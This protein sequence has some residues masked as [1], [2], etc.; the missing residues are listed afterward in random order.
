VIRV[1]GRPSMRTIAS[2][3]A[4]ALLL[5]AAAATVAQTVDLTG[6]QRR[7]ALE[8]LQAMA[9]GDAQA[10]AY[11]LHPSET[12][13]LRIGLQQRL[14]TE[15]ARG[16]SV[17]RGRLFGAA[18]PLADIERMTSVDFFRA[19]GPRLQLRARPYAELRGLAAVRDGERTLA[20][21][22]AKPP[23]ER[24]ETEVVEVVPLLPYGKEWKAAVPSEIEARL[25]D[26]LA[27]R[28]ARRP[29]EPGGA[30]AG[31]VAAGAG[32]TGGVGGAVAVTDPAAGA[33]PPVRNTPELLAMLGAAEKVLVEGRCEVYYR[34]H[35][36]P[37]L[38]RGLGSRALD[39]LIASCNRSIASREL[40][41]AA[42]RLVQ[43]TPPVYEAGGERAVYDLS[44]QGLPYD[45]YVLERIDRRWY[46]AE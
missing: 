35:L 8:F 5:F 6:A 26:L 22:K 21:V 34:E 3:G 17:L 28:S 42:L 39:T 43:R 20:V 14:R 9:S 7:A 4:C 40:L 23:R 2:W 12:D 30:V 32:G 36:S 16:E 24:G 33:A 37:T 31:A 11:A 25:E 45:R 38:R 1:A 46:I 10:I 19:L 13:R 41:I 15:A 44:G 27:G 29:G 18:M